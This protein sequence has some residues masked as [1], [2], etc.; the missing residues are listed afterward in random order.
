MNNKHR[1]SLIGEAIL[2][3]WEHGIPTYIRNNGIRFEKPLLLDP[4]SYSFENN[5]GFLSQDFFNIRSGKIDKEPNNFYG[6]LKDSEFIVGS[7]IPT[8]PCGVD[9]FFADILKPQPHIIN[10]FKKL[11]S[12]YDITNETLGF[13][14]R[15]METFGPRGKNVSQKDISS[16]IGGVMSKIRESLKIDKNKKILI[17]SDDFK[18]EQQFLK[19]YPN[20]C[21]V[22]EEDK[23]PTH[24]LG[25]QNTGRDRDS[26]SQAFILLL[27]LSETD[28]IATFGSLFSKF[29]DTLKRIRKVNDFLI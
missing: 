6:V 26:I 8:P 3:H 5:E 2:K 25:L 18:I 24:M 10:Q 23:K 19:Q 16:T 7:S 21:F 17:S 22:I 4:L 27:L 12:K 20:N 15:G 1:L 28:Y 14:I 9:V 11:K 13:H 29:P